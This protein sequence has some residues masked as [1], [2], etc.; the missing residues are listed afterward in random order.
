MKDRQMN[1]I[2]LIVREQLE[3]YLA[4]ELVEDIMEGIA[5]G[6]YDNMEL[7]EDLGA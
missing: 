1:L 6:L 7:L 4:D 5:E 2:M 3:E